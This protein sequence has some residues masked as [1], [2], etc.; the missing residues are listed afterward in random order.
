MIKYYIIIGLALFIG[1]FSIYTSEK[2][3]E[4]YIIYKPIPLMLYLTVMIYSAVKNSQL[5][6]LYSFF[7]SGMFFALLGDFLL[8]KDRFLISGMA[9]FLAG[10]ILYITY[11]VKMGSNFNP[12]LFSMITSAALIYYYIF[13]KKMNPEKRKQFLIPVII[14]IAGISIMVYFAIALDLRMSTSYFYSGGAILFF[15]SDATIAYEKFIKK[16]YRSQIPILSTYYTAQA[17][18]TVGILKS[19]NL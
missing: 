13:Q 1:I 7:I 2:V 18:L 15:I 17:L 10:H 14:Y 12:A 4:L 6:S 16:I 19:M 5:I 3:R 9:S 8:I 11:F